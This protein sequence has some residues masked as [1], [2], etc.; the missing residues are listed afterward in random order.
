[1]RSSWCSRIAHAPARRSSTRGVSRR[2]RFT[3]CQSRSKTEHRRERHSDDGRIEDAR[4]IRV[5]L[6]RRQVVERL[7]AAGAVI[8]GRDHLR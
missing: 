2:D 8:I 1:M 3:V 4:D 7:E 5:A 6:Q